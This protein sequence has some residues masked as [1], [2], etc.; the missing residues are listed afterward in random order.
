MGVIAFEMSFNQGILIVREIIDL[1]KPSFMSCEPSALLA[2]RHFVSDS[3]E[4]VSNGVELS[5]P[6]EL[7]SMEARLIG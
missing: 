5:S 6:F 4:L 1:H 2:D 7:V 3:T